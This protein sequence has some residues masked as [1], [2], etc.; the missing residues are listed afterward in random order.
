MIRTRSDDEDPQR[1]VK[2]ARLLDDVATTIE[3]QA[4]AVPKEDL[5]AALTEMF[6]PLEVVTDKLALAYSD[7]RHGALF[8]LVQ[9]CKF[10]ASK[11]WGKITRITIN[12]TIPSTSLAKMVNLEH[13]TFQTAVY[14][15]PDLQTALSKL[16]QLR[17]LDLNNSA[18][19]RLTDN[20]LATFT[21][22]EELSLRG[23]NPQ[24]SGDAF[25][26]LPALRKLYL[27]TGPRF[28][29]EVLE[30]LTGL[31]WLHCGDSARG[32][33]GSRASLYIFW[34]NLVPLVNLQSLDLTWTSG[35]LDA[36]SLTTLVN[37][38][39]LKLP[40]RNYV[41]DPSW[42]VSFPLLERLDLNRAPVGY[43]MR[44]RDLLGLQNL[45]V[46]RWRDE[47]LPD[48]DVAKPLRV[49]QIVWDRYSHDKFEI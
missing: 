13:L 2:H 25:G 7:V 6:F 29:S 23:P 1:L 10:F 8:K 47:E 31:E 5:Y 44:D 20:L 33:L 12:A 45:R 15:D 49:S 27:N 41:D 21:Q 4:V 14:N 3:T 39:H 17:V 30:S 28:N 16:K 42:F 26:A 34:E 18:V 9:T 37:L 35:V 11:L 36:T 32:Y 19:P 24:I 22:L 48:L 43:T 38:R 46:I 40:E